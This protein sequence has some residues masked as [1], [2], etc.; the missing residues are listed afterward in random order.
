MKLIDWTKVPRGT[1]TN[2]GEL[3]YIGTH[4]GRQYALAY[5]D[6]DSKAIQFLTRELRIV[7]ATRWMYHDC[8]Q[9]TDDFTDGLLIEYKAF[10]ISRGVIHGEAAHIPIYAHAYR[11]TGVDRAGGFTDNPEEVTE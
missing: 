11:I 10:D 7:P 1:M 8:Y 3:L 9:E 4:Q 2:M 5:A 6:G